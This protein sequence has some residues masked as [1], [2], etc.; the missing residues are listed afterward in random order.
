MTDFDWPD[1]IIP[2]DVTFYLQ[3][4]SGGSESPFSRTSKIYGLSAPRW[5]CQISVRGGDSGKWGADGK[6]LWGQRLDAFLAKVKGRQNRVRLWDFRRPGEAKAFTNALAARESNTITLTGASPGDIGVGDYI[7][8]DGRPHIITDLEDVGSDLVATV[9]PPFVEEMG[10]GKATYERSSGYFRL[11]SDDAGSNA[12]PVGQHTTY[13]LSFVEDNLP[14]L[15]PPAALG[16]PSYY[17]FRVVSYTPGSASVSL[18]PR[19]FVSPAVWTGVEYFVK[20]GGNDLNTGLSEAQAFRTVFKALTV[21]QAGGV[22]F[23]VA[24]KGGYYPFGLGNFITPASMPDFAIAA[25]DGLAVISTAPTLT[26]ANDGSGTNTYQAAQAII[27]RVFDILNT[28]AFG[29]YIELTQRA[30]GDVAGV[31][32]NAG[33][34]CRN[35]GNVVAH[36][37]DNAVVSDA[38]T[39]SYHQNAGCDVASPANNA[40]LENI[41]VQGGRGIRAY[42][43]T[44]NLITVNCRSLYAGYDSVQW[45]GMGFVDMDGFF[46]AINPYIGAC[47]KDD[48]GISGTAPSHWMVVNGKGRDNGRY[49]ATSTNGITSHDPAHVGI[50]IGGDWG[51]NSN[52][53]LVVPVGGSKLWCLGTKALNGAAEAFYAQGAGSKLWVERTSETGTA[54]TIRARDGA[55]VYKREH[56]GTGAEL[57]D[58]APVGQILVF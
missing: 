23:R 53:G 25:Y 26:W 19:S 33:S 13:N 35:G 15:Q 58:G 31:R 2:F 8:G 10:V 17:A 46:L 16:W 32:A 28:D 41:E 3:P 29:H 52:G 9:E 44:G 12:S 27:A 57:A 42:T 37:A 21:G 14:M 1:D 18:N 55:T 20:V 36:R 56:S 48:I 34:W 38:N 4:H 6:A 24:L 39:R 7:G 11:V 50:D 30:D 49:G 47:A 51:E 45:D 22:P 40:Y 43:G 54:T 5:V